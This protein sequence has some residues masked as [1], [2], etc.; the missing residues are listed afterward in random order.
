MEDMFQQLI[1]S[2]QLEKGL[3]RSPLQVLFGVRI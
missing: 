2:S 3:N 1:D